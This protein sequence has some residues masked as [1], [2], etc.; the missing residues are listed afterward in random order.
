MNFSV[1]YTDL[2]NEARGLLEPLTEAFQRVLISGRYILGQELAAFEGEFASY[3]GTRFAAGTSSGTAALIVTL[4]ALGLPSNAEVITVSNSFVATA[5]AIELAGARPVF[6][7]I[8]EDGNMDPACIEAAITPRTRAIVPVHLTGR[9][10]RMLEIL[11]IAKSCGLYVIEDAAQAIGARLGDRQVGSFGHVA[12]FSLNPL[13]NLYAIGD[14]GIVTT[15]DPTLHAKIIRARNHGL[16]DR[17]HCEFFSYN[18]RLDELQAAL[19]RIQLPLLNARIE[20]RRHLAR[21]YNDLLGRWVEVPEERSGEY[22]VYQTYVVRTKGRDELQH[23]LRKNGVEALVHYATAIYQQPAAVDLKY[24]ESDFP[25][26]TR[27]VDLILS[28]PLYP[29]LTHAQQDR[30]AGLVERFFSSWSGPRRNM[31]I[32]G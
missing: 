1:P 31:A 28:L 29:G 17:E 2:S 21:R 16:I 7:D 9:P 19:L 22:C 23:Y 15:N 32:T 11:T 10:A 6:V 20:A 12:C 3:C 18:C 5:A 25:E 13:K 26:T 4:R 27:H 14:G 8:G 30:V 24:T